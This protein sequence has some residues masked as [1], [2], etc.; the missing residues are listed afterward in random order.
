MEFNMHELSMI[1]DAL[2]F[3][4]CC[5]VCTNVSEDRQ[6]EMAELSAKLSKDIDHPRYP[7]RQYVSED[8]YYYSNMVSEQPTILDKI[9]M[10]IQNFS[11]D[12]S[13]E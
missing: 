1:I 7:K 8:N 12:T 11:E 10:N 5:D 4:S 2:Q 3:T 6:M 9:K 13:D